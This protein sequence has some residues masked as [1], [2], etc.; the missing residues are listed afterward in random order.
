LE[1]VHK[2]LTLDITGESAMAIAEA[3]CLDYLYSVVL[4]YCYFDICVWRL[5]LYDRCMSF[6]PLLLNK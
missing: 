5:Q 6:C 3:Q 2:T 4:V 1:L